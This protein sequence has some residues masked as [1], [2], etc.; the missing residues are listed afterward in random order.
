MLFGTVSSKHNFASRGIEVGTCYHRFT[1][2][3]HG[4]GKDLSHPKGGLRRCKS[5]FSLVWT[6]DLSV[7]MFVDVLRTRAID[8]NRASKLMASVAMLDIELDKQL[9]EINT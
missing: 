3:K 4:H 8:T 1:H 5:T 2:K 6:V 9:A 7:C